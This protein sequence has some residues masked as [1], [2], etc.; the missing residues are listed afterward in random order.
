MEVKDIIQIIGIALTFLVSLFT[1]FHYVRK[2][3]KGSYISATTKERLFYVK[4]LRESIAEICSIVELN[5]VE[6][7]LVTTQNKLRFLYL[8]NKCY[9]LLNTQD[10]YWEA[11]I[12]SLLDSL[13]EQWCKPKNVLNEQQIDD[14]KQVL[15][16]LTYITQN[17]L[18]L[19]WRGVKLEAKKGIPSKEDI[20]ELQN[21][22]RQKYN[23]YYGVR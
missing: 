14:V 22:M 2:E 23:R 10:P 17:L 15:K 20:E 5:T 12:L 3:K 16:K 8:K 4:E 11:T 1:Y 18:E 13:K 21:K 7:N 6:Q 9:L 19:E